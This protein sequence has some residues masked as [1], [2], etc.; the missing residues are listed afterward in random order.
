[1][2][3]CL[4]CSVPVA[5]D[6][7]RCPSCG[8]S[9]VRTT[10]I[11]RRQPP[12]PTPT[13]RPAT[14]PWRSFGIPLA[15]VAALVGG[16]WAWEWWQSGV[17]V[18]LASGPR[19]RVGRGF[20]EEHKVDAKETSMRSWWDASSQVHL[21]VIHNPERGDL[22]SDQDSMENALADFLDAM[23]PA[24]AA[25]DYP[26]FRYEAVNGRYTVSCELIDPKWAGKAS[27]VI[28]SKEVRNIS[29][30]LQRSGRHLLIW[31]VGYND[32]NGVAQRAKA[33]LGDLVLP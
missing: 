9:L 16:L 7:R 27:S 32:L 28:S 14:S 10:R 3:T 2:T 20:A 8:A 26:P 30:S 22:A 25:I 13:A 11:E 24:D 12:P 17:E 5:V 23:I 31:G 4:Q 18:T 6:A 15:A 21:L 1:M 29:I 33:T 19:F